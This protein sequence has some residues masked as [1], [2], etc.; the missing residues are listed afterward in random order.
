[1]KVRNKVRIPTSATTIIPF[2]AG[3]KK[4]TKEKRVKFITIRKELTT[5]FKF[6]NI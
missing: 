5:F 2:T 1:M 6:V 4:L 3:P